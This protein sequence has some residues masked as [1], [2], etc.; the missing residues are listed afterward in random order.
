VRDLRSAP[1]RNLFVKLTAPLPRA[2]VL[3]K[4]GNLRARNNRSAPARA[5][6]AAPAG[7]AAGINPRNANEIPQQR[8]PTISGAFDISRYHPP[9]SLPL[10]TPPSRPVSAG[11]IPREIPKVP[12]SSAC[13]PSRFHPRD[14]RQPREYRIVRYSHC[15][16]RS[17]VEGGITHRL[18]DPV[19]LLPRLAVGR[20]GGLAFL[21]FRGVAPG[22]C[23]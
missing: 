15:A 16:T 7:A 17:R 9:L 14:R 6:R 3:L 2:R 23:N 12:A 1:R 19:V 13:L 11:G 21:E 22:K 10:P 5:P 4:A 18:V 8:A 20:E